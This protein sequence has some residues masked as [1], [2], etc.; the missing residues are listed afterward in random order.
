MSK[1][2]TLEFY[3]II[4]NLNTL[5]KSEISTKKLLLLGSTPFLLSQISQKYTKKT[6]NDIITINLGGHGLEFIRVMI[7]LSVE[8]N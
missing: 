1:F 4:G 8:L 3:L 2:T 5:F 6:L 7:D